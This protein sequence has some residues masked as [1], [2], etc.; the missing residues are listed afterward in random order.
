M[1]FMA[2]L[3]LEDARPDDAEKEADVAMALSPYQGGSDALDAMAI[4]AAADLLADKNADAEAWLAKIKAVN[5]GRTAGRMRL[6]AWHLVL[7]RRY[8]EAVAYYR[9][10]VE[11]APEIGWRASGAGINLMRLGASDEA[12]QKGS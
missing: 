2:D 3:A 4:R 1:S 9:K 8:P 11:A 5:P 10:A 6:S 7:N 12:P